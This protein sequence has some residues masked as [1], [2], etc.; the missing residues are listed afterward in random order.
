MK[1]IILLTCLAVAAASHLGH[2][3]AHDD[4]SHHHAAATDYGTAYDGHDGVY[5][6][7]H[8]ADAGAHRDV[9]KDVYAEEYSSYNTKT[10]S[11]GGFNEDWKSGDSGAS[12]YG[13]SS[14]SHY[15]GY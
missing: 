1:M 3:H 7:G 10:K 2:G 8:H 4:T 9:A 13:G 12:S 15:L 5:D 11:Q 6:A 14:H